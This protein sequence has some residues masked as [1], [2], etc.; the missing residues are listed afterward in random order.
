MPAE[1]RNW[2]LTLLTL[3]AII[4]MLRWASA[5][6]IPVMLAVLIS[7]TLSPLVSHLQ[8]WRIPVP[9]GRRVFCSEYWE[10]LAV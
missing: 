6:F 10:A 5:V 7:Y 4:W 3:F 1:G 9:W 8:R 2:A